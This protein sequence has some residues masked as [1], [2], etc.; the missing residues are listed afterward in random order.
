MKNNTE[1]DVMFSIPTKEEAEKTLAAVAAEVKTDRPAPTPKIPV[2]I[3]VIGAKKVSI[4]ATNEVETIYFLRVNKLAETDEDKKYIEQDEA[5]RIGFTEKQ[6]ELAYQVVCENSKPVQ[7]WTLR[8][9]GNTSA[10]QIAVINAAYARGVD[11]S[12]KGNYYTNFKNKRVYAITMY[13]KKK[14]E[15]LR[16]GAIAKAKELETEQI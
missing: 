11:V 12:L 14:L 4:A 1:M 8:A 16:N 3:A 13:T 2:L 9:Q 7:R 15:G 6:I 10:N 5:G